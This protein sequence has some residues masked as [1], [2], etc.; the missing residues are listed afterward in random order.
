[1][2]GYYKAAGKTGTA[3]VP[4]KG[5][6]YQNRAFVGYAPYDDPQIAVACMSETQTRCV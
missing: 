4:I 3:Q 6:E 2:D 5:V 1:M